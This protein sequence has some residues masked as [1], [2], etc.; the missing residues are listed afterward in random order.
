[1]SRERNV[2]R[3]RCFAEVTV[4]IAPGCLEVVRDVFFPNDDE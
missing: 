1:V 4:V 2:G 3:E